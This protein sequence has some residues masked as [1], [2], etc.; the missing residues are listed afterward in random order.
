M[1][2]EP[3]R[4]ATTVHSVWWPGRSLWRT[5]GSGVWTGQ[6]L[7]QDGS[8]RTPP[9]PAADDPAPSDFFSGLLRPLVGEGLAFRIGGQWVRQFPSGEPTALPAPGWLAANPGTDLILIRHE[10]A[11]ALVPPPTSIEGSGCQERVRL[12]TRTGESCGDLVLPFGGSECSERHLGIALDGTVIQQLELNIPAN[13]QCAWR[14]W[15]RLL[16]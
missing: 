11:Y 12:F 13:D 6:W 10:G 3:W 2:P 4:C 1:A 5:S 15:P 16:R 7:R 8:A 14:W 9:F